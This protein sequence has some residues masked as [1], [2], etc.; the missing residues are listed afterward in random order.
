MFDLLDFIFGLVD[1]WYLR[2]VVAFVIACFGLF[3]AYDF[4]F[5]EYPGPGGSTSDL[6]SGLGCVVVA[7]IFGWL[8]FRRRNEST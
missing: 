1:L 7:V 2:R 3:Y 8:T 5:V 6:M 4:L